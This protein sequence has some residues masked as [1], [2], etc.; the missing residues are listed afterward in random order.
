MLLATDSLHGKLIAGALVTG[1]SAAE[2]TFFLQTLKEWLP[3]PVKFMTIDFSS[4]IESG[5][6]AV[7]NFFNKNSRK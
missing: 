7:F 1:E 4:R 6:K 3:K 2:T 5:V